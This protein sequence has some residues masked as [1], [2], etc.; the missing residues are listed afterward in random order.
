MSTEIL[1][2][3]AVFG[4]LGA[5]CR[6]IISTLLTE[7]GKWSGPGSI[8]L[9]NVLGSLGLGITVGLAIEGPLLAWLATGF[10]GGF[11]TF[12]TVSVDVVRLAQS[13][14]GWR[15]AWYSIGQFALAVLF[16]VAGALLFTMP[17]Q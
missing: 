10:F 11:T 2:G 1:L 15:A 16:V 8:A 5:A 3:V 7:N 12:G 9:I 13:G 6:Y 14:K 17:P 4:G